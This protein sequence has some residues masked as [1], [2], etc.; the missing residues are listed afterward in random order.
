MV[1][2]VRPRLPALEDGSRDPSSNVLK[3]GDVPKRP[4]GAHSKCA[5]PVKRRQGS[6]PCISARTKPETGG[7]SAST[8][9]R[10][11]FR[12]SVFFTFLLSSENTDKV[13][14]EESVS[15]R[16]LT[17]WISGRGL[18]NRA[19]VR[20][21]WWGNRAGFRIRAFGMIRAGLLRR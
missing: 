14:S 4:K 12:C 9:F 19:G 5:R 1:V 7:S 15:I 13:F 16:C 21:L 17:A 18:R 2:S 8:G 6:N 3:Y 20:Y 10:L 11:F